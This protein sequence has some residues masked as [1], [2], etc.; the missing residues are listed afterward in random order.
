MHILEII[1]LV[2]AILVVGI[3]VTYII[4]FH[5]AII[6]S[7][8]IT[9]PG[10][11][12]AD[13]YYYLPEGW[14]S[15]R[16]TATLQIERNIADNSV[17][18][19]KV[20]QMGFSPEVHIK[21]D[22]KAIVSL[23]YKGNWF[24]NDELLVVTSSSALLE[25]VKSISED[26]MS[27]ITGQVVKAASPEDNRGFKTISGENNI[28]GTSV[29]ELTEVTGLFSITSNE[30]AEHKI[31]KTWKIQVGGL[32]HDAVNT[33]DASFTLENERPLVRR[34]ISTGKY[35]GLLTRPLVAQQWKLVNADAPVFICL[36][37][38]TGSLIKVP[39]RRSFFVKKQ[40]LPKFQQ[41]LLVEQSINKPSEME[42]L[43][44]VPVNILKAIVSIPAQLLQFKINRVNQETAY[45]KALVAAL[46]AKEELKDAVHKEEIRQLQDLITGL[47]KRLS[48]VV[49]PGQALPVL[50]VTEGEPQLGKLP[51]L[52]FEE[53]RESKH[54]KAE[55]TAE[56]VNLLE[57]KDNKLP[58]PEAAK[59]WGA[60]ITKWDDYNNIK[61]KTCVPASAAYLLTSWTKNSNPPVKILDPKIIMD[62]LLAVAPG[63]NISKGCH[64]LRMLE[65]WR[66][67]GM[68]GEK[69]DDF[70]PIQ[71]QNSNL[72]KHAVYWFG[73]CMV[74]LMLPT[75]VKKSTDWVYNISMDK[76]TKEGHAICVLGF[77]GNFFRAISFG[78]IIL[79]DAMFYEKFNDE[80]YIVLSQKNWATFERDRSPTS[81]GLSYTELDDLMM[82]LFLSPKIWL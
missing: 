20:V 5:T 18:D 29:T 77:E 75:S 17:M 51:A 10:E 57:L 63:Q 55:L 27:Y 12:T 28:S 56:S 82:S 76:E 42:G 26:R 47:K 21:P 22:N 62:T 30:L 78:K 34:D 37:P 41:G 38:D 59:N 67:S 66:D 80:T 25:N 6:Q 9:L 24:S 71:A 33:A 19:V 72:L 3:I 2:F 45:E 23:T 68:G 70:K 15:L 52:P 11:H 50:P 65:Y 73:G 4:V 49:I 7:E 43:I 58:Q 13:H 48:T 32:H 31:L 61:F 54:S 14:I 40:Q 81:P 69:I 16:V 79:M 44:S 74:G 1:L 53:V 8:L 39:V 64:M 60:G 46:K 36:I 35:N